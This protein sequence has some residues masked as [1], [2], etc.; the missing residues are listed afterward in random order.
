[1][2]R[3]CL[4]YIL[5]DRGVGKSY[6]LS[7]LEEFSHYDKRSSKDSFKGS[8]W[9]IETRGTKILIEVKE[10][11]KLSAA[12]IKSIRGQEQRTYIIYIPLPDDRNLSASGSILPKYQLDS[13]LLTRLKEVSDVATI[14]VSEWHA[15]QSSQH[16]SGLRRRLSFVEYFIPFYSTERR[17]DRPFQAISTIR[18][19][20]INSN[21]NYL[22]RANELIR[23][24]YKLKEKTLDLGN[25]GLTS[26]NEVPELFNNVHLESLILSNEWGEYAAGEWKRKT[27]KNKSHPNVL[28]KIPREIANLKNLKSLICGGSWKN[29]RERIP[30]SETSWFISDI[31]H[32]SQLKELS[33]L[34][35]SNNAIVSVEIISKLTQLTKLYLNN[36][37]IYEIPNL[38]PLKKLREVYLSNNR[39]SNVE[40]LSKLARVKT[41]DLHS[42]RITDL[43]PI[44]KLISKLGI[45]DS[46]WEHDTISIS[47]NR[48]SLPPIEVVA[49]GLDAVLSFFAQLEAEEKIKIKQYDNKDIKLILVG[50][51]NT[52]KS[53]YAH[54]LKTGKVNKDISTTHWLDRISIELAG[55]N[56]RVLDF[57]GQEY[58]HDTHHL[59]FT[60][61]TAYVLLWEASSNQFGELEVDQRQTNLSW[62]NVKIQTFPLEYWLDSIQYHTQKRRLSQTERSIEK[63]LDDRD[64]QIDEAIKSSDNW[65][66]AVIDSGN[67]IGEVL[68]E[69]RNI[70]VIQNKVDDRSSKV[71]INERLLKDSYPNISDFSE[72]SVFNERGLDSSKSMLVDIFTSLEISTKQLLGTWNWI[73]KE[74]LKQEFENHFTLTEFI[75][76]CN[77]VIKKMPELKGKT[78]D[79]AKSVLFTMKD[80]ENFATFLARV[81]LCLF[82]PENSKLKDRIFLNQDHIL[83][84][85]HR[86]L[87][88]LDRSMGE[89]SA[90][91]IA[92]AIGKMETDQDVTDVI[93]L[94]LHF[95][96][97]FKHPLETKSVF[98]AP[99]Y[100]PH[101]PP[102]SIRLFYSLFKKPLYRFCYETFIHKSVILNF[103]SEYGQ[104]ALAETNGDDLFYYWKNG[105]VLKDETSDVIVMVKF[106]PGNESKSAF[107]DVYAI[108]KE[109]DQKFI[110]KIIEDLDRINAG[111]KVHKLVPFEE[112][113][114]RLDVILRNEKAGNVVFHYN[115]KYYRLTAFKKYLISPLKMKKIFISY[116]KQDLRLVNKFIEH[117][118]ALQRDGK[119]GHWYCSE[120][121]AGSRWDDKIQKQLDE[122]DIVCFMISPNFMKTDYILEHE[123]PKAFERKRT[124]P[125]FKIVPIILDFCR[126]ATTNNNLGDYTALPYTAKPVLDFPNENMAWYI[127]QECLRLMIDSDLNPTGDDFYVKQTLP[128]DVA[129]IYTR[130]V[131]GKVD[132]NS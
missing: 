52:G 75:T 127:I 74:I 78:T 10:V 107:L 41:I 130:I 123:V 110:K 9:I 53:S 46:R 51:S 69:E 109:P 40:F 124:D 119:V 54:W 128:S 48:L 122:S 36:N 45:K 12:I 93:D 15:V 104:K 14:I 84:Q 70:L 47:N 61:S 94:M 91:E 3:K 106:V 112:E 56:I 88:R 25:C 32:L 105:I 125:R 13:E 118:A 76:F 11:T 65:P 117:L 37:S 2:D 23:N 87:A 85:I 17:T 44:R 120:L 60:D 57:G 26:L 8:D 7:G 62:K 16:L 99:L 103:F 92:K 98:V 58:Y 4:L 80:A 35:L 5:G 95:K 131:E 97:L 71:F 39:V 132:K 90:D 81:G 86:V 115:E 50:N 33:I 1:M 27:S 73:K 55:F 96:I 29:T 89:I 101:D 19:I 79:Q 102:K 24:N 66:D 18:R 129:K 108:D 82:Y 116:S 49:I 31:T 114:V 34:N 30:L 111:L 20:I 22:E 63:L 43:T 77:G 113:F 68:Q 100:L 38:E 64:E 121:E 21:S 67:K 42:N 6:L 59:L 28:F 83:D 72:V 126:W